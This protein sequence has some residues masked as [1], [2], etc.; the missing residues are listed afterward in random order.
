[1]SRHIGVRTVVV[2]KPDVAVVR[3]SV[4]G[5]LFLAG[6]LGGYVC[7]GLW[8]GTDDGSLRDYLMGFCSLYDSGLVSGGV[9][10]TLWHYFGWAILVFLAGFSAVGAVLIPVFS[11]CSG[12]L[13]MYAVA[14]FVRVFGRPGAL[15][16]LAVLGIRF[17][18]TLPVFFLLAESA[19]P[20]AAQLAAVSVGRGKRTAPV[21]YSGGYFVRFVLCIVFLT[22]GVCCERFLVPLLIRM[23]VEAAF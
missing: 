20:Q 2:K 14:C 17:L 18:F 22:V 9:W 3:L 8:V 23:A 21:L 1:M 10:D 4:L 6:A 16:A 11:G 12:F 13:G 7:A 19:W 5:L 15:V